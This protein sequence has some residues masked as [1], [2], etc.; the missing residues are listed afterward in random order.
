MIPF[1]SSFHG[2]GDHLFRFRLPDFRIFQILPHR[3]ILLL[4]NKEYISG[5]ISRSF[6]VVYPIFPLFI[7]FFLLLDIILYIIQSTATC[8]Y[9]F[10]FLSSTH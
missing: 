6:R 3:G 1:S 7:H 5:F 10:K 2:I 9:S 4:Y 8:R